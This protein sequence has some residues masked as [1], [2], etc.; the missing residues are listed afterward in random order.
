MLFVICWV[1]LFMQAYR[2]PVKSSSS[3]RLPQPASQVAID[4]FKKQGKELA[5]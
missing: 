5:E 1:D 2:E 4:A 3:V